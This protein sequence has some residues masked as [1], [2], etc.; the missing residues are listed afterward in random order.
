V[1]E[2]GLPLGAKAR[3]FCGRLRQ[4]EVG[5]VPLLLHPRAV[6]GQRNS[7]FL[8][9]AVPSTSLRVRL[10]LGMTKLWGCVLISG[11][12]GPALSCFHVFA[13]DGIDGGLIATAVL[14]EKCEDVRIDA[15]GDLLLGP[16]PDDR[17]GEK[18]GVKLWDV[19]I[20]DVFVTHRINALPIRPGLPFRIL[21]VLHGLPFSA[22]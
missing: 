14:A 10:A 3:V 20:I 12:D 4:T 18:I 8:D 6:V 11:L 21:S 5:P 22:R 15:Q 19:G 2:E 17:P 13:E 7:R 16:G 1:L 9:Y